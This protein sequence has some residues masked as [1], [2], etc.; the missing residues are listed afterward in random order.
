M[1]VNL[2]KEGS[3]LGLY[4]KKKNQL[5]VYALTRM[6]FCFMPTLW[7]QNSIHLNGT[8]QN[9]QIFGCILQGLTKFNQDLWNM[10]EVILGQHSRHPLRLNTA[11]LSSTD[12]PPNQIGGIKRWYKYIFMHAM[13][14]NVWSSI[15]WHYWF[16]DMPLQECA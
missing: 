10:R 6:T 7:R 5:S 14:C 2:N 1:L 9:K 8:K 3:D 16:G 11:P 13:Q 15:W 4:Y 12:I